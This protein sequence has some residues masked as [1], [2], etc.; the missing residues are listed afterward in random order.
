MK[1]C[2][3]LPVHCDQCNRNIHLLLF[4]VHFIKSKKIKGLLNIRFNCSYVLHGQHFQDNWLVSLFGNEIQYQSHAPFRCSIQSMMNDA[5]IRQLTLQ[6]SETFTLYM[7]WS[8]FMMSSMTGS[9]T[10]A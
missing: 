9:T 5:E 8:L 1:R 10:N 6:P 3:I 4:N 7:L 2:C